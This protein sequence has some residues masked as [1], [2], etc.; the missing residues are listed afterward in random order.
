MSHILHATGMAFLQ[1]LER[2]TDFACF[3][4]DTIIGLLKDKQ[5]FNR[6]S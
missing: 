4:F 1:V 3:K 6:Y 2:V 5:R